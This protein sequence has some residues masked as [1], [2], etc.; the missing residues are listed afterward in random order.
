[1]DLK[2][3]KKRRRQMVCIRQAFLQINE[4][5]PAYIYIYM[6]LKTLTHYSFPNI[7]VHQGII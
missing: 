4:E 2:K 1:M 6:G 3:K 7:Y 5:S